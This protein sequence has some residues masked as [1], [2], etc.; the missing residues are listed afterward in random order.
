[1]CLSKVTATYDKPSSLI[2]DGW[3][4]FAGTVMQP[5]FT[6]FGGVVQLGV[7][8]T[9]SSAGAP[10]QGIQA[11]DGKTYKA[12]FHAYA[13]EGQRRGLR[14]VYLRQITSTG[15]QD[16]MSCVVAQEMYVPSDPSDANAWPP[17]LQPAT[18]G[19]AKP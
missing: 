2:V 7:W 19:G 11:D 13:N 6:K 18:E 10:P 17:L 14:R 3:K 4:N 12:G 16:G 5:R 8:V 9:A 15:D 1:M